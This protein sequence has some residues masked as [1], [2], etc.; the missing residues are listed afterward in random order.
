MN[1]EKGRYQEIGKCRGVF[2]RRME[3]VSWSGRMTNEVV[4]RRIGEKRTLFE[5]IYG[6]QRKWLGH[7][8]R[9]QGLLMDVIEGRLIGKKGRGRK[10]KTLFC[11]WRRKENSRTETY[12]E[13][14]RNA[15]VRDEWREWR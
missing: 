10:K 15:E 2:R 3:R 6:R 9:H 13:I 5:T 7:D 14:K 11:H 4:L 1:I 8:M 12:G